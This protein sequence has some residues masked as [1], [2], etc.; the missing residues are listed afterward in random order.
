MKK[1]VLIIEDDEKNRMLEKDLLDVAGMEVLEARDGASGLVLARKE[2]PDAI[3]ADV[4][5]PDMRGTQLAKALQEAPET[6]GIPVI[7]V[8]ASVSGEMMEEIRAFNGKLFLP[9]PIDTRT[10]AEEIRRFIEA[11]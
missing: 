9:K 3:V 6:R 10:F 5:L 8:T 2:R 7:F 11:V 4:R 1:R